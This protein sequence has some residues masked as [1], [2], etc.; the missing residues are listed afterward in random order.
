MPANSLRS[1]RSVW[2]FHLNQEA[3]EQAARGLAR[4]DKKSAVH[5]ELTR[6]ST[7]AEVNHDQFPDCPT[8]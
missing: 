4:R 7:S 1:S 3:I 8:V 2:A 6:D 5:E